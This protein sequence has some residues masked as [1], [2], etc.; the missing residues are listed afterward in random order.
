MFFYIKFDLFW[1]S[2]PWTTFCIYWEA[3]SWFFYLRMRWNGT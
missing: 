1:K 3:I 2:W